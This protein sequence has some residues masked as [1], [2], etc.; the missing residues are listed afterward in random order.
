MAEGPALDGRVTPKMNTPPSSPPPIVRH[1]RHSSPSAISMA[2]RNLY[3]ELKRR[4]A[5][6]ISEETL[7]HLK[8]AFV[9]CHNDLQGLRDFEK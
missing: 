5:G 2:P 6:G 4:N 8:D 3:P 1:R 7:A 9:R